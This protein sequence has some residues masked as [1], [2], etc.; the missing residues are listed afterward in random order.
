MVAALD[1]V[2]VVENHDRLTVADRG[3]TVRDNKDGTSHHQ[4][5]HTFLDECLRSRIDRACRLIEDH[6]R[7]IRNGCSRDRDELS[8]T[9]GKAR[10]ISGEHRIVALR[11]SLDKVIGIRQSRCRHTLLVRGVQTTIADVVHDRAGK[12]VDIL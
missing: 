6:D 1:D 12:Q 4:V 7:R 8:L 9:L 2:T 11:Q 5:V 3:K 10:T